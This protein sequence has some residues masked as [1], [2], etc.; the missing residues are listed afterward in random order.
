MEGKLFLLDAYALIFR[1]YY[2]FIKNP[3]INTRGVNTSAIFG[4][5]NTLIDIIKKENPTHIAVVFDPPG[6]SFRNTLYSAYKAN[7]DETPEVIRMSVPI[8]KDVIRAFRIPVIEIEGFEAD[9]TIGTLAKKLANPDFQV[10]MMTP[11][12]DYTQLVDE[13]IRI[14]KPGRAGNE[15]EILDIAKVNAQFEITHPDQVRDILALW[16]DSSDNIPGAPG[17]GEKTAKKLIAQYGT[18]ESLIENAS[19][20]PG[21]NGDII[22]NNS[23]QILLAKTLVTIRTDVPVEVTHDDLKKLSPDIDALKKIFANLEFRNLAE[24]FFIE[25]QNQPGPAQLDL[26]GQPVPSLQAQEKP[27]ET[28]RE[29]ADSV[30]A[31]Y[32][33]VDTLYLRKQ[34]LK[35]LMDADEVCFDSETTGL[36][37]QTDTIVGL[38]FSIQPGEAWY[39]AMPATRDETIEV[40]NEFNP[41]WK[42]CQIL[43]I[44]QNL[45]FDILMLHY[46]GIEVTGPLFDTMIAHYLIEPD[47][48]HNLDDLALQYLNYSTIHIEEL[49]GKRSSIQKNMRDVPVELITRYAG[50]DADICL[51]LKLFFASELKKQGLESLFFDV[52]MPLLPVLVKM[53]CAGVAVDSNMLRNYSVQ[54]KEELL[55]IEKKIYSL[56][57]NEFNI[58]SPRQLG[59]IL[60]EKLKITQNPPMTKTKQYATGEEILVKFSGT[61]PIVDEILEYRSVSK[62]ISTYVDALPAMVSPVTGRIH[63]TYTQTIAATGRLS[64]VNPNLQNIPIREDRG[65]VLR[66]AFIPFCDDC[67]FFSADYSQ[68]ELRIMAHMSND[69]NMIEAFSQNNEDIHT[70]TAA[71]I[72]GVSRDEVTREMRSKAKTAN[73]GIIY[74]ISAFGLAQRLQI[75]RIEAKDLIDSYFDSFPGVRKFIDNSI[76]M[77]RENRYVETILGRK[78]YLSDIN[79]SN[80]VVRGFAERNAI[81]APIQGSAA[82]I[83]KLA[84]INI[85]KRLSEGEFRSQM[86]MQV[87][88]ELNFNVYA[89]E[90]ETLRDLVITEMENVMSLSV[91][92]K[93]E[94][95]YGKNWLEAH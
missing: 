87:H 37:P 86:I 59:V 68:I 62:L 26:F 49:I 84:M 11:D 76:L 82:D 5:T 85:Q 71:K 69:A 21:R 6:G 72:F 24:R 67:L 9:D 7:R 43:K 38:S 19:K 60:F 75:S 36:N 51:Q 94:Y 27:V 13:N 20:L 34:L 91:P 23:A 70:A 81:N 42:N 25:A 52:E 95:G 47:Q 93:A 57:G 8:I 39:V 83:I 10:F 15:S 2:A 33:L 46:H 35:K 53:E 77:A 22:K 58:A 17:I 4:F 1:S 12:K 50:E 92:L 80:A 18:V 90:A 78:R 3:R 88:D 64:S 31:K 73:F 40:I 74:G 61:H 41:F 56:A 32:H 65:R 48:K 14:Y 30:N 16:G 28:G 29:N 44:G 55:G 66:G 89:S 54:L 45:K 63:T 79:S